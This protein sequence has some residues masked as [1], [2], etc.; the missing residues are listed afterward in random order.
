MVSLYF[1][2]SCENKR[3]VHV[4]ICPTRL[5]CASRSHDLTTFYSYKYFVSRVWRW[6]S[7]IA[8]AS[9]FE[10]KQGQTLAVNTDSDR[11]TA[12]HSATGVNATNLSDEIK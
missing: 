12:K 5:L 6:L 2:H 1:V 11:S 9:Q 10:S 4:I 8:L 3:R 7:G